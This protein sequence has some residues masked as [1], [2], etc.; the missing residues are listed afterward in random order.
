M[1]RRYLPILVAVALLWGGILVLSD[2]ATHSL[3]KAHA[4]ALVSTRGGLLLLVGG[5][6]L[7]LM[8]TVSTALFLRGEQRRRSLLQQHHTLKEVLDQRDQF[9]TLSLDLI[10]RVSPEGQFLQ[11]NSGF[12]S[13]LGYTEEQLVGQPYTRLVASDDCPAI[14]AGLQQ[15]ASGQAV[16]VLVVRLVDTRGQHHWVEINAALGSEP[17]IYVVARDINA[18]RQSEL[19]L[20]RHEQ[21]FTIVGETARVG[22]WYVRL[23]DGLPTWSDEI[24]ALHDEAPGFQP[25]LDEAIAFYHPEDRARI[26][27]DFSACANHGIPFDA[28]YGITTSQGREMRVRVVANALR[29]EHDR[30]IEVQGSTQDITEQTALHREVAGLAKRLSVTLESMTDGFFILDATW[31]FGYAN[32]EAER[33]LQRD[34]G[35][36]I[37]QH[38]WTAFP[39]ARGSRFQQEYE[40]AV[41]EQ[42]S[43]HFEAFTPQLQLWVEVHAYPSNEGLAVYFRDI[44]QRRDTDRQLRLLESSVTA[45]INGVV[46]CDARL[47][48]MPIVYVNPAFEK[49]TGYHRDDVIGHNCRLLQ[50]EQTDPQARQRLTLAIARRENVHLVIKNYRRDGSTFWNELYISAVRDSDGVVTHFIG[51]QNDISAQKDY[52]TQLSHHASHDALTGLPNRTLLEERLQQGCRITQRDQ[53]LLAVLFVDLDGFKPINDTL[54]HEAGDQILREVAGRLTTQLRAADTV[55]RFGGDEFVVVLPDL[56]HER[57]VPPVVERL[58]SSLSSPYAVEHHELRITASIGISIND[59]SIARPMQLIQRADLAM[60]QAKRQGR[61]TF[62]WFTHDLDHQ[63]SERV[64][65]RNALQRAIEEQQFELYYQPQVHAPSGRVI[66]L[67]ALVRWKHPERGYISPLEFIGLAE[68]TGQIIPISDWVLSTAC[69]DAMHLNALGLGSL[70][71]AVNISPMQFQRPGFIGGVAKVLEESGLSPS[72]LELE[73]TE[74]VLMDSTERVIET[75]QTLREH[76]VRVA[77]DDFGTG[78]SSLSYLKHLPISKIKVDR[79]FVR[80]VISDHRDAAI[81]E[82]VVTMA[83]KLRLDVVIEGVETQAQYAYLRKQLCDTF[84]GYLFARPMPLD[85]LIPF[86]KEYHLRHTLDQ[87][88]GED[89]DGQ[90]LLLLDDEPNILRALTRILR[91]AGYRILT[92]TR[93]GEAFE[94][95]AGEEIQVIISD[96]RM[97]EMSGTE[98]LRH[99]TELYPDA[100]QIMLSGYTDLR[101]VTEAINEGAIYKFLTKPW[102]DDELRLVVNQ[103]FRQA[104]IRRN[105]RDK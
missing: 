89:H 47:P 7:S 38:V 26:F 96:Q 46:I 52:E 92:A 98:F 90:T 66:G 11:V 15:L 24:C 12:Y 50:G 63:V 55:A 72:L 22:G 45:S 85:S 51:V 17:A 91:P 74:G 88:R 43:A 5:L 28:E 95:L 9:F 59:G 54:G 97:P 4:V 37:G 79:S 33:L 105:K 84:Q 64:S 69:R 61:N 82:G 76:G 81:I 57:D 87:P 78:F 73:L 29:D 20:R 70:C 34:T 65:L 36:L 56:D 58:L 99:V 60:Y 41:A 27:E 31:R 39:E 94:L 35:S 6:L 2:L 68:D 16:R 32:S 53:R 67:E 48:D 44:S 30:I 102:D 40:R 101:T 49:I 21:F 83:G 93:T 75:L 1:L 71:M 25:T 100:I 8:L 62:H 3:F 23:P 14:E 104:A 19:I 80:D 13:L 86:L 18:R 42:S 103:A 10:C 77:I